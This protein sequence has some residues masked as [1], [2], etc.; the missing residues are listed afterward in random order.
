MAFRSLN[1]HVRQII[2]AERDDEQLERS[3]RSV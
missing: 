2:T 3:I 1:A